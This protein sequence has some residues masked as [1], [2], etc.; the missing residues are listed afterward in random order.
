VIQ[1]EVR[2]AAVRE[3]AGTSVPTLEGEGIAVDVGRWGIIQLNESAYVRRANI[4]T[5]NGVIH[6]IS[7]VLLPPSVKL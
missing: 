7:A 6:S 2:A 5:T 3:A 1:G 4:D